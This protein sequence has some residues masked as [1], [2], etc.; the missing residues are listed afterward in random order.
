MRKLAFT[1]RNRYSDE[2]TRNRLTE[3]YNWLIRL[4][5][6]AVDFTKNAASSAFQVYHVKFFIDYILNDAIKLFYTG[7]D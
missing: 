5:A 2:Y 3:E 4:K 6:I 7:T 1:L